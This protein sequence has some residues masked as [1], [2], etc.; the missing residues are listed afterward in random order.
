[1]I[2]TVTLKSQASPN[3]PRVNV[4][5]YLPMLLFL[6][7]ACA[8]TYDPETG[9]EINDQSITEEKSIFNKHNLSVGMFDDKTG[10]SLIGYTYNLTKKEKNE[11]FIGG[12]TMIL[13]FTGSLGWKHY[14]RKS[15]LSISS[16]I[17]AQYVA[18]LGF[19][20]F[21]PTA[22]YAIEYSLSKR[23]NQILG[24]EGAHL[25]LG[26]LGLVMLSGDNSGDIGA[27]P[28]GGLSFSF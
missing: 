2:M 17:C 23:A 26:I 13:G 5:R 4:T 25:K 1:M 8:Q 27:I 22:S 24:L 16:T 18:H 19:M 6:W 9:K 15:K 14:Y 12:G 11:Y 3:G 28:F 7:Y 10:L 20:G 21:M